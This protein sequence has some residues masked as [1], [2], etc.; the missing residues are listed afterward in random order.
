LHRVLMDRGTSLAHRADILQGVATR[1]V[2]DLFDGSPDRAAV[3]RAHWVVAATSGLLLREPG[4]FQAIRCVLQATHELARHSLVVGFL[5]MGLARSVLGAD[6]GSLLMA[7]MAG[8]LHDIGRVGHEH[9]SDDRE[10]TTRG[11]ECLAGL[12]VAQ[13]VI[14]VAAM[15][16]ERGDGSGYPRGLR[17]GQIADLSQVVGIADL[18]DEIHCEHRSSVFESLRVLAFSHRDSF[19]DR[20]TKA[21]ITLFR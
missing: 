14:E 6:A 3:Q 13:P 7:G 21:L 11:A 9:A 4:A 10:H 20:M 15:H 16:H 17:C 12:G 1:V 8:L 19:D 18:F 5:S 2:C